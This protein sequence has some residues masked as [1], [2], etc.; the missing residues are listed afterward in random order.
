MHNTG[1]YEK[2]G[3]RCVSFRSVKKKKKKRSEPSRSSRFDV[4]ER[5]L[6]P[7]FASPTPARAENVVVG[8]HAVDMDLPGLRPPV[9]KH[10]SLHPQLESLVFQRS[11]T[12]CNSFGFTSQPLRGDRVLYALQLD[13]A[14]RVAVAG[15][16]THLT[17]AIDWAYV[18]L[19]LLDA[20]LLCRSC[21]PLSTAPWPR[22]AAGVDGL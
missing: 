6:I 2:N 4:I 16:Y 17:H 22:Y 21:S 3:A 5:R 11:A 9:A 1:Q 7:S 18:K 10:D 12:S 15:A 14:Q 8:T 20:R 19:K 13:A